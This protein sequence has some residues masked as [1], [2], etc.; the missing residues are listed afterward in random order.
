MLLSITPIIVTWRGE[1]LRPTPNVRQWFPASTQ[2]K[3]KWTCWFQETGTLMIIQTDM[4]GMF[5]AL[6][7][8]P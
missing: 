6:E 7:C 4:E 8:I 2:C 5:R 3:L 1:D